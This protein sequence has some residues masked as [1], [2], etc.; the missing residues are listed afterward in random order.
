MKFIFQVLHR[1]STILKFW[2]LIMQKENDYVCQEKMSSYIVK[3][4]MK[5]QLLFFLFIITPSFGQ[6]NEAKYQFSKEIFES[7]YKKEHFKRFDGKIEIVNKNTIKFGLK[8][9]TINIEKSSYKKIFEK[10]IFNPDIIFGKETTKTLE[11]TALD[12]LSSFSKVL[13][14]LTRNDSLTICCVDELEKLNPNLQTKRFILW[15]FS[16]NSMNST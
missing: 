5:A 12:T 16:I 6:T 14:N 2:E 7:R 13:Y 9:L 4:F 11:K 15:V 10:G 1:I 8:T 3:Y